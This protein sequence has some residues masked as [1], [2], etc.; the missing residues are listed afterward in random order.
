MIQDYEV[1]MMREIK[2]NLSDLTVTQ[3]WTTVDDDVETIVYEVVISWIGK[4]ENGNTSVLASKNFYA[5]MAQREAATGG[6]PVTGGTAEHAR[7]AESDTL[8]I[9]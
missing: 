2:A 1:N 8:T 7:S 6:N 4:D 3:D 5:G 9:K